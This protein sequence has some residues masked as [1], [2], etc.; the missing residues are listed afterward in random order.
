MRVLVAPGSFKSDCTAPEVATALSAG[1]AAGAEPVALPVADGGE[2]RHDAQTGQGKM[3][4]AGRR[5]VSGVRRA[6]A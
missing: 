2:G 6:A 1:I 3:I 4:E 5:L